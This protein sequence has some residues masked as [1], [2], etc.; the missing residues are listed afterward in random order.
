MITIDL[1]KNHPPTTIYPRQEDEN[2]AP[3][4]G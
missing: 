1:L 3:F 2:I 4:L